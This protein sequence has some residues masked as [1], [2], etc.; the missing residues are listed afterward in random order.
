MPQNRCPQPIKTP[1][2]AINCGNQRKNV[3]SKQQSLTR[4]SI[5]R[6]DQVK[7]RH[8]DGQAV[9]NLL[10][11]A[12]LRAVGDIGLNLDPSIHRPGMHH[13]DILLAS[14][15]AVPSQPEEPRELAHAGKLAA[16]YALELNAKHADDIN[17]A[18]DRIEIVNHFRAELLERLGE[19]RRRPDQE[20][21]PAEF[22]KR[23]E[24]RARN[25]AVGDVTD[26]RDLEPFNPAEALAHRIDVE[27][28]LRGML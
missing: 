18:N 4:N 23:P 14:L 6:S 16:F 2:R 3:I 24:V 15:E 5:D 27:Q 26:D 1:P 7:H 19:Q 20:N 17:L 9:A 8:P 22:L 12:R 21:L 11:D 13:E 28:A 25:P 10:E